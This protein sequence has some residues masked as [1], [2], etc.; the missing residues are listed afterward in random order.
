MSTE[1]VNRATR[2]AAG[3]TIRFVQISRKLRMIFRP[4]RGRISMLLVSLVAQFIP[5]FAYALPTDGNVVAGQATVS[6]ANASSMQINQASTQAVINWGTFNVGSGE[7]V[8]FIQPSASSVTLNQVLGGSMSQIY[9]SITANGR[10]VLTNPS[11]VLFYAGAKVDTAGL[12]ASTMS[13]NKDDFMAGHYVFQGGAGSGSVVNQGTI[14]SN[15]GPA[16]LLGTVF[17]NTGTISATGGTVALGAGSRATLDR[18]GDGMI[19]V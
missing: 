11:G 1:L 5:S 17:E 14:R 12:I 8:R 19:T 18:V 9:G 15:G 4:S 16:I 13:M 10:I 7:S 3:T 2:R 6:Q